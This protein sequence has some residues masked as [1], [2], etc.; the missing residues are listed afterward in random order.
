MRQRPFLGINSACF[1]EDTVSMDN[2]QR[3]GI[4]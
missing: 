2:I 1:V 4:E 3:E